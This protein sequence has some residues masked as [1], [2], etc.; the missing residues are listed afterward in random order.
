MPF[1]SGSSWRTTTPMILSWVSNRFL[2]CSLR[3][4][5]M[6]VTDVG[7]LSVSTT[8]LSVPQFG[9]NMA[10]TSLFAV[11][12]RGEDVETSSPLD[13][14]GTG[15]GHCPLGRLG[16]GKAA[17]G[18]ARG[19]KRTAPAGTYVLTGSGPWPSRSPFPATVAPRCGFE[20]SALRNN[21]RHSGRLK[22]I[23]T[24]R[25]HTAGIVALIA[26]SGDSLAQQPVVRPRIHASPL[27]PLP[28][29]P[30]KARN[31]GNGLPPMY[32]MEPG[33]TPEDPGAGEGFQLSPRK[34]PPA[35]P[36]CPSAYSVRN[37][38]RS[39]RPSSTGTAW[40]C[41]L[42]HDGMQLL[43]V[44]PRPGHVTPAPR[45]SGTEESLINSLCW[46]GRSLA[47]VVPARVSKHLRDIATSEGGQRA[48]CVSPHR[49]WGVLV[50]ETHCADG[51]RKAAGVVAFPPTRL[52]RFIGH[53][54]V[55]VLGLPVPASPRLLQR[56]RHA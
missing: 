27:V 45:I 38:S 43:S 21:Y 14:D 34:I 37:E 29:H 51:S 2:Q 32:G 1:I 3:H 26:G 48:G 42:P 44:F 25:R 16:M 22:E 9:Q 12:G 15:T 56:C 8:R 10:F 18:S 30:P 35:H 47:V 5:R 6:R 23:F 52:A 33:R 53:R 13:H 49:L 55:N 54:Y 4:H 28:V 7:S 40:I 39:Q 19:E 46:P 11:R 17:P 41:I 36:G 20:A 50:L 31:V 24:A